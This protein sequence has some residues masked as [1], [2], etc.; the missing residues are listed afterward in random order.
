MVQY[1]IKSISQM[2]NGVDV[3]VEIDDGYTVFNETFTLTNINEFNITHIDNLV[4]T[5]IA[6]ADLFNDC[7]LILGAEIDVPRSV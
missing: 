3:R 6:S 7:M 5:T 1:T 4:N 2:P